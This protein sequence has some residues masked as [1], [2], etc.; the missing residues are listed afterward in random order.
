MDQGYCKRY[1]NIRISSEKLDR[2]TP[3]DMR[4]VKIKSGYEHSNM[5]M[6]FD[7]NLDEKLT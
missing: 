2:V 6:V 5:H 3:Y 1:E 4:K 7:I